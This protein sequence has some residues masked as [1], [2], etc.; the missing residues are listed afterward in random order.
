MGYN[1]AT[2]KRSRPRCRSIPWVSSP[3]G[4]P[5]V[6]PTPE[7]PM[8]SVMLWHRG[9]LHSIIGGSA[10][11]ASPSKAVPGTEHRH[12]APP[13]STGVLWVP[14][15][16][17][18]PLSRPTGEGRTPIPLAQ[19][20]ARGRWPWQSRH[21]P[22]PGEDAEW[23]RLLRRG[24]GSS[25]SITPPWAG[26]VAQAPTAPSSQARP[27]RVPGGQDQRR[28]GR[29]SPGAEPSPAL[30]RSSR[31]EG[32]AKHRWPR[33]RQGRSWGAAWPPQPSPP[34]APAPAPLG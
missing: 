21:R 4:L 14:P 12:V 16:L 32:P 30:D 25:I 24:M 5:L 2:A 1:V 18:A 20:A 11:S 31:C 19:A 27:L 10:A 28:Q 33:R 9:G 22:W 15:S 17:S 7:K 23:H 13:H 26:T 34:A 3:L 29:G 6:P 8:A